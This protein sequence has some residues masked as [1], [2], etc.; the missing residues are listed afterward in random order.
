M[1]L[2][3]L[4][5]NALKCASSFQRDSLANPGSG[6]VDKMTSE[7]VP[8]VSSPSNSESTILTVYELSTW[9]PGTMWA[10]EM[11]IINPLVDKELPPRTSPTI[12]VVPVMERTNKFLNEAFTTKLS[13]LQCKTLRS[14]Y[15]LQQNKLTKTLFLDTMMASYVLERHEINGPHCRHYRGEYWKQWGHSLNCWRPSMTMSPS[16]QWIK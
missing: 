8:R 12:Q 4:D 14:H 2:M 10:K 6:A 9:I 1:A 16:Y 15:T 11:D 13:P 5:V 3:R 7:L